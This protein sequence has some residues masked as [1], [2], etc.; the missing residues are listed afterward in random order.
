MI[1][2]SIM[3]VTLQVKMDF[4][5]L[6]KMLRIIVFSSLVFLQSTNAQTAELDSMEYLVGEIGLAELQQQPYR[7][8]FDK[9]Y[10]AHTV[11]LDILKEIRP[12]LAEVS[13]TVFMGTWCHDSQREVPALLKILDALSFDTTRLD[14]IALTFNKDT[15]KRIEQDFDIRRTPTIVFSRHEKEI[16]RFVEHP[17]KTLD[18]DI[19]AIL[20]DDNYRHSYADQ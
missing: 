17:Q 6:S 14:I 7:Q 18:E 4:N 16:G 20:K 13:I 1:L 11:N 15:P 8:W 10:S 12:L 3:I 19:L 2:N 9:H 5:M